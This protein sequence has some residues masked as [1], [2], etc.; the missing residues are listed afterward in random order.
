MSRPV[1]LTARGNVQIPSELRESLDLHAGQQ[2]TAVAK[3]KVIMLVP[4]RSAAEMRG[5][6]RGADTSGYRDR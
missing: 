5:I 2:Y 1:T 6:A 3:G 4:V